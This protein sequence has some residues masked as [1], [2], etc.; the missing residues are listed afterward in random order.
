MSVRPTRRGTPRATPRIHLHRRHRSRRLYSEGG[1][2]GACRR[3]RV[4]SA[5]AGPRTG[6]RRMSVLLTF[7][8]RYAP[9]I[10]AIGLVAR[11]PRG[12]QPSA[13]P[14][15]RTGGKAMV[16]VEFAQ[17]GNGLTAGGRL[18]LPSQESRHEGSGVR[19]KGRLMGGAFNVVAAPI[20][21]PSARHPP[22]SRPPLRRWYRTAVGGWGDVPMQ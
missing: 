13:L 15:D 20:R 2:A 17:A 11:H 8:Y 4:E 10:T 3:L 7:A 6:A 21:R 14:T 19:R 16:R 22:L 1:R 9:L 18:E 12:T 5:T